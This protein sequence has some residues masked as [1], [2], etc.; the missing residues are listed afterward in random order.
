MLRTKKVQIWNRR[1]PFDRYYR[2]KFGIALFSHAHLQTNAW[3][4]KQVWLED[5]RAAA[6]SKK[7]SVE[8]KV[9]APPRKLDYNKLQAS[10]DKS[11]HARAAK[12][13]D[14]DNG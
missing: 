9:V 2:E 3:T 10:L 4:P 11:K 13:G 12:Q 5:M 8:K 1:F 6:A 7:K 14:T